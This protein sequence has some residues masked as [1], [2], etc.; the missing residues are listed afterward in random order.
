MII[1]FLFV[2]INIFTT[3]RKIRLTTL[4]V[5]LRLDQFDGIIGL[6]KCADLGSLSFIFSLQDDNSCFV[7]SHELFVSDDVHDV[8]NKKCHFLSRFY[9]TYCVHFQ[10]FI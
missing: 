5:L 1:R 10:L 4:S 9:G 3:E 2:M 6:T 7:L 8:H